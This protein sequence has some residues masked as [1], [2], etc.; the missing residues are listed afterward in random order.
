MAVDQVRTGL[1][2]EPVRR[3][4]YG[5]HVAHLIAYGHDFGAQPY[6]EAYCG[7]APEWGAAWL[8]SG[9]QREENEVTQMNTCKRCN[10]CAQETADFV[11]DLK[12]FLADPQ[13]P[14]ENSHEQ[15]HR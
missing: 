11:N 2:D 5:G 6:V 8:G 1:Q 4:T 7:Y 10:K 13:Q 15:D 14:K 12:A 3:F 9:T